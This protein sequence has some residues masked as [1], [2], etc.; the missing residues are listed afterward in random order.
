[1]AAA[2]YW[3]DGEGKVAGSWVKVGSCLHTCTHQ[4]LG[5]YTR[6]PIP[7][8]YG[9]AVLRF[10]YPCSSAHPGLEPPFGLHAI[11]YHMQVGY[12]GRRLSG[13]CSGRDRRP[14]RGRPCWCLVF[15]RKGRQ[16]YTSGGA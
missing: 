9:H 10:Q 4:E 14:I 15:I 11:T 5:L 12:L 13:V 2:G 6:C 16:A 7:F 8:P 3:S 1:M